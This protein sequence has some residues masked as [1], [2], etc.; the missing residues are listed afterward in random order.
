MKNLRQLQIFFQKPFLSLHELKNS[1]MALAEKTFVSVGGG[2]GSFCW[3]NILRVHGVAASS[4]AV[5]AQNRL[6]YQQFKHYCDHSG[7]SP[8]D[9][10]RS[11]SG[12]RPDN[13]WGFPGYAVSEF[14]DDL[15]T[16]QWRAA[17]KTIWQIFAEPLLADFY[18]PTAGRLYASMAR[19]GQR[20]G[21]ASMVRPGTALFLRKLN[22]GRFAIFYQEP[23]KKVGIVVASFVHLALGHAIRRSAYPV[24][25]PSARVLSGYELDEDFFRTVEETASSVVVVG[26]GIVAARIVERLLPGDHACPNRTVVS[27]F[28][29]PLTSAIDP[30]NI[31]Q[32]SLD[33][34]RLQFF[35]WP[36]STFAGQLTETLQAATPR[37]RQQLA[38]TWSAA[39]TPP[40]KQWLR[41][42]KKAYAAQTYQ[43]IYGQIAR[44]EQHDA[45]LAITLTPD[46]NADGGEQTLAADYLI[47]CSG[48]DDRLGHHF[49]YADLIKTYQ[50]GVT[51]IGTLRVN[52]YFE[53]EALAS[54]WGSVFVTGNGAAG[55]H[56]GPVDSFWGHQYA[57]LQSVEKLA[58]LPWTKV[59]KL[60]A[61]SSL[62]GWLQ[63]ALNRPI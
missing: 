7:L 13:F 14:F 40:R 51:G 22:D 28:R 1:G 62:V 53:I 35:N 36:R 42:L 48:F 4:I 11:D 20:I 6:P 31:Q 34:W 63:W 45:R 24:A 38:K 10:L 58:D 59:R 2:I 16:L 57:A 23:T 30:E 50:L 52:H 49:L 46:A 54:D 9:R 8:E 27:L 61:A 32:A 39:S 19:E 60:T 44:V 5:V 37:A 56:Y 33:G 29:Q 12:A 21:W 18:T 43:S 47:D 26:R 25:S 17:A 55:N 15:R 3:V 41:T